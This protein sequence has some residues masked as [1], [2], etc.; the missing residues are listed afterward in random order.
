LEFLIEL[1]D[2][3]DFLV[4]YN[5][6]LDDA[7]AVIHNQQLIA[8]IHSELDKRRLSPFEQ[9]F[10][11]QDHFGLFPSEPVTFNYHGVSISSRTLH[12]TGMRLRDING[13]DL[14]YEIEGEKFVL[15]QYKRA[16]NN[17]ITVDKKQ[18][19]TLLNNCP[20]KCRNK[21]KRPMPQEWIPRKSFTYCGIWY[22]VINNG[23]FRTVTACEAESIFQN[24]SS[25]QE[26]ILI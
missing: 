16:Y 14:L 19:E 17:Q 21:Q 18:L 24:Q 1:K 22:R 8:G 11:Y 25:K 5:T 12:Q 3:R 10:I 7:A 9:D 23:N 13:T 6:M 4:T 20:E 2:L 15:L 26:R